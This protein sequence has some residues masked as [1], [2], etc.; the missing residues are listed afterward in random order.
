MTMQEILQRLTA[1]PAQIL[2]TVQ[3]T[4][5]AVSY[6]ISTRP[7]PNTVLAKVASYVGALVRV[8]VALSTALMLWV[9]GGFYSERTEHVLMHSLGHLKTAQLLELANKCQWV[10]AAPCA[11]LIFILLFRRNYV[12]MM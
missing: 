8:L 12:G 4:P 1:P 2:R 11:V 9:L 3:P 6:T 5:L 10:Y 7:R